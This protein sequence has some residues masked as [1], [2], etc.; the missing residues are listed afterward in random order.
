MDPQQM[1]QMRVDQLKQ[2]FDLTAEQIEQATEL[3]TKQTAE[4]QKIFEGGNPDF[5]QFGKIMENEVT[6]MKKILT[7]DQFKA[8]QKQRDEQMAQFG[9]GF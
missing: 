4:F 6:E 2:S 9:G 5:S 7:E 1:V 3:Y 8:W